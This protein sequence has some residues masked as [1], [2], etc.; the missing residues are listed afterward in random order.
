M[1]DRLD[2]WK[3]IAAYLGREVRTV[4][5]WA[6]SRRLPVH[7]L[8]G[9]NKPRVY[10][11]KPELDG[12]L[13]S[14]PSQAPAGAPSIA[15]LPF[16]SLGDESTE[17]FGDGLADD[18]IDALVRV[19]GLRVIARTSSFA[20]RGQTR[21]VRAIG[22]RLGAAN[23][24][25]GSIRCSGDRVR[26]SAQLVSAADGC[27]LWSES[28]DRLLTDVF[29]VQYE[30]AQAIAGALDI[31]LSLETSCERPP[32]DL[33]AYALWLK[34]RAAA[35]LYTAEGF[36]TA[37]E[38]YAAAIARDPRF[39]IPYVDAAEALINAATFGMTPSPDAARRAR[40]LVLAA[41]ELNESL[42]EAH[43][44]RGSLEAVMGH[45]WRAAEASF[46]RAQELSPG[47]ASVLWRHAW[48]YLDPLGR[49]EEEVA[50]A[51]EAAARDPLS[52]LTHSILG[53]VLMVAR[54]YAGAAREQRLAVEL[55]PGL[56]YPQWFLGTALL[57]SGKL[58][59]GFA[60]CRSVYERYG[61]DPMAV[62][63]MSVV[64]ALSL[65]RGKARALLSRLESLTANTHV[66]P[67]AFAW[68][69][70]GLADDRV[71]D[72]LDR[73]IAEHDPAA[74]HMP[75]M[76]IYDAIRDDPRFGALL[77]KMN[78]G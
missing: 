21:D 16:V 35:A 51:R 3:S 65:R 18:I 56:A 38:C 17:Y 15:V 69:Y 36:G 40:E 60:Q 23:L 75:S 70:L 77:A 20:F 13:E 43:A 47:S 61:S 63:G 32:G 46:Q 10:A 26:V 22:A 34:G 55:A 78:L 74:I 73:A 27:H 66:P 62:G 14:G 53:L 2:S 28:Y 6:V 39:A 59:E 7:R 67:L 76:P 64:Y 33:R 4:Q 30:I 41:L 52:A 44:V 54:D 31:R 12:W 25:E 57:L 48:Y 5:R 24:L 71:F 8:P 37:Q 11:L 42:G 9:G 68:A 45:D 49:I 1:A 58:S 29:A 72:W 50:E 19:P